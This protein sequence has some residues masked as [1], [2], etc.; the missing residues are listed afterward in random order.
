[1][2]VVQGA[3]GVALFS[4][5]AGSAVTILRKKRATELHRVR[6]QT[7]RTKQAAEAA[8]LSKAND[9]RERFRVIRQQQRF[10]AVRDNNLPK[11]LCTSDVLIGE[12]VLDLTAMYERDRVFI[13]FKWLE[14]FL[15]PDCA[16]VPFDDPHEG[17]ALLWASDKLG[18]RKEMY[19]NAATVALTMKYSDYNGIMVTC[20]DAI[21]RALHNYP[22]DDVL[23]E[24]GGRVLVLIVKTM[25]SMSEGYVFIYMFPA[26]TIRDLSVSPLSWMQRIISQLRAEWHPFA[27]AI[28]LRG[29]SIWTE[30]VTLISDEV[31][32]FPSAT[33]DSSQCMDVCDDDDDSCEDMGSFPRASAEEM[34]KRNVRCCR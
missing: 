14:W 31:T 20:L 12:C 28:S 25:R 18:W 8:A 21:W 16:E 29:G 17:T 24:Y 15:D 7:Y 19:W 5:V 6:Q 2:D 9:E 33:N 1:M 10:R 13:T 34:A 11:N 27:D 26:N 32:S 22:S 30:F 4:A 23:L 3:V